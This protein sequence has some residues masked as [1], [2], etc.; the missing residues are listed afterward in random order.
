[1]HRT[2]G[3][4]AAILYH[5]HKDLDAVLSGSRFGAIWLSMAASFDAELAKLLILL[6]TI[7]LSR[8]PRQILE[9]KR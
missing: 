8:L 5:N 3:C 9:I 1:M 2:H 4:C 6:G 7:R